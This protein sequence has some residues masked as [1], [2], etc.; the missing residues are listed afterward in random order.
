M[1]IGIRF[2][3]FR[4]DEKR[5]GLINE[6]TRLLTENKI[7]YFY[8]DET[9]EKPDLIAVF[10]GDGTILSTAE[11]AVENDI[12]ILAINIGTVGFLSSFEE[13]DL[14][15]AVNMIV[16]GSLKVKEKTALLVKTSSGETF[17]AVNDAVIE[18]DKRYDGASVVA[19]LDFS[20]DGNSIYRLSA[21]GVIIST[22]TGST[23]YSLSAGGVILT[24][25][26]NS[27]IAT[28]I[29]SHSLYT[30]PI[31]YKDDS[32][33]SIKLLENSS[34]STLSVD[35]KCVKKLEVGDSVIV[36]KHPKTLKI[37]DCGEDFFNRLITKLGK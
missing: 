5:V 19:K 23:A 37:V 31:V 36:S 24:P 26:L 33:V 29:C 10:G 13:K 7:E 30:R 16:S 6:F 2:N 9:D 35:G 12:S 27:F 25:N 14:S 15:A 17:F 28:P 18:R 11:Y 1:K 32:V 20:I 21:D 8:L 4:V 3:P 22:P 34:S